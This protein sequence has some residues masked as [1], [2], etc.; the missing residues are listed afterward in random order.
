MTKRKEMATEERWGSVGDVAVPTG[1]PS[2]TSKIIKAGAL[3]PDTKA[4]L[5][6]WDLGLSVSENLQRIRHQNLLGKSS[7]SRAEDILAIFRQRYLAED[8]V[9]RALARLVRNQCNGNTIARILYFHSVRADSLL[10]DAV[11][12]LLMPKWS[13]GDTDIDV[14]EIELALKKW[15]EEGKTLGTWSDYTVH[16]VTQGVLSTLRDFGV[17]QGA[18]NKR[19]APAYLSVQAFSYIAFYLKQ[20]QPSGTKLL[21][22]ADWKLFFLAR[23]GVERFLLEAHQHNLVEYHVAGTVTRLTF[24]A[25]TLEEYADVLTQKS[26]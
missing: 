1:S 14:R 9:A 13:R 12:E 6:H 11:I 24:P 10:R 5:S 7:R 15:V 8:S 16:R 4:L 17:L 25:S 26:N 2:Y 20:Y 22:L 18:V 21:D 19:I 3:L 23:E